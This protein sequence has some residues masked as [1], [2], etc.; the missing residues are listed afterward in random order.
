MSS[1][2]FCDKCGKEIAMERVCLIKVS[3]PL[4]LPE[5]KHRYIDMCVECCSDLLKYVHRD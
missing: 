4:E 1:K 2:I 5:L 3:L